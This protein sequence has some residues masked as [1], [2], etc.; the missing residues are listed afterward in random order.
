MP[1]AVSPFQL[2]RF[3]PQP[4]YAEQEGV[5]HSRIL[6]SKT[7]SGDLEARS[8]VEMLT[9]RNDPLGAGYVALE[10]IDGTLKGRRGTFALLH[11]GTM[12]G[13]TS[14]GSWPVSPG[15]GTGELEGISGVARIEIDEAGG[16]TLFLDYELS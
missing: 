8:T 14:S 16:H 4:P 3:E 5:S 13:D 9:A 7:F 10:R 1:R 12:I 6:I 2:D 15:S 11:L